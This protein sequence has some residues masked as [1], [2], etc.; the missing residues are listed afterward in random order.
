MTTMTV[1][2]AM[3]TTFPAMTFLI[4]VF[5]FPVITFKFWFKLN[6]SHLNDFLKNT[7]F[8]LWKMT[9]MLTMFIHSNSPPFL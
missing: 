3:M 8:W 1:M 9:I 5:M 2:M 4:K 6:D 7:F